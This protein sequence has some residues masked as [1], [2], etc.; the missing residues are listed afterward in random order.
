[1]F[2]I[3]HFPHLLQ[4]FIR[5]KSKG[6]PKNFVRLGYL[7]VKHRYP[8]PSTAVPIGERALHTTALCPGKNPQRVQKGRP[9]KLPGQPV[10]AFLFIGLLIGI[11]DKPVAGARAVVSAAEMPSVAALRA[12]R[13]IRDRVLRHQAL[14]LD[15]VHRGGTGSNGPC[16][17]SPTP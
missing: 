8:G 17:R 9:G 7:L 10:P 1:M 16:R 3:R 13:G 15:S 14:H 6:F 4:V 5:R 2:I 12:A 11:G